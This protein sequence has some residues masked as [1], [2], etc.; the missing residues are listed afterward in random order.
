MALTQDFKEFIQLL[1][2]KSVKYLVV[3]GYAVGFYGHPRYT[4][5]LDL[6]LE[7]SSGNAQKLEEALNEFGFGSLGLGTSDFL[8]PDSVIQLG[9]P[10]ARIDLIFGVSGINFEDCFPKREIV[11]LDGIAINLIDLED[12]KANKR[13]SG[14]FQDLADLEN[15]S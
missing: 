15:L 9:Y 8:D 3:G 2:E 4:K 11:H 14:R 5:D 6:W 7:C 10:P 1:N 12:L 13:A